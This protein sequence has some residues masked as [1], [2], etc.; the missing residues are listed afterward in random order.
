MYERLVDGTLVR[1]TSE[2]LLV[3]A[4]SSL[5]RI[6]A[7]KYLS[8]D[9]LTCVLE[10]TSATFSRAGYSPSELSQCLLAAVGH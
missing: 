5:V 2:D 7:Q 6:R 3:H 9:P 10:E 4:I 8:I 1:I